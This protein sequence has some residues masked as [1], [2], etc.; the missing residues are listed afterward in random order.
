MKLHLPKNLL[1]AMLMTTIP[2]TLYAE[3]ATS[4]IPENTENQEL[5]EEE[6]EPI[7]LSADGQRDIGKADFDAW[8]LLS[9]TTGKGDLTIGQD[10]TMGIYDSTGKLITSGFG[11]HT[12]KNPN[13]SAIITNRVKIGTTLSAN[14]NLTLNANAVVAIGGEYKSEY[15]GLTAKNVTVNNTATLIAGRLE[16][17]SLTATGA[18]IVN[19]HTNGSGPGYRG[20]NTIG[21]KTYDKQTKIDGTI[22]V[23]DGATVTIGVDNGQNGENSYNEQFLNYLGGTIT[24]DS[25]AVIDETSKETISAKST[26]AIKGRTYISGNLNI[27]QSGGDME[28]ALAH[29]NPAANSSGNVPSILRLGKSNGNTI[30]QTTTG[31]MKIG[32]IACGSNGNSNSQISIEQQ[33]SGTIELIN[34]VAFTTAKNADSYSTIKQT[35]TVNKGTIKLN[36]DFTSAIFNITQ[37]GNGSIVLNGSMKAHDVEVGSDMKVYGELVKAGD[38]SLLTIVGQGHLTNDGAIDIDISMESGTLTAVDGSTFADVVATSGTIY[39]G[40]GVT[41]GSLTLGSNAEIAMYTMRNTQNGVTV[42]VDKGG[43]I[44]DNVTLGNNVKF[45]VETESTADELVGQNITIFQKQEENGTTTTYDLTGATVFVKDSTGTE[46]EVKFADNK[47]GSVTV[48]GS[49]PEPTTATL[50]LL[51]LAA[52]AARRRRK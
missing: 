16:A 27:T 49:I 11:V 8:L 15:M 32:Q 24:Q 25:K 10:E 2:A 52:L 47:D 17:A 37:E 44:A 42:Y 26:L 5:I 51:A 39:L 43:A 48:S 28:I 31:N 40:N 6:S 46:T 7:L 23:T 21:N 19:L 29:R 38:D 14:Y 12:D 1:I 36:G 3:T 45:V 22:K 35:N 18:S 30:T 33:G 4:E 20:G 50:S 13:K 9:K 34:G 41:F